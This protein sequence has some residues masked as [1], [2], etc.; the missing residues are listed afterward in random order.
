M[1]TNFE[2]GMRA[3]IRD[4]EWRIK[5]VDHSS[6]GGYVLACEGLSEL[7]LGREG[8]FLSELDP[9][10]ILDPTDTTLVDDTSSNFGAS[11]L[12]LDSMLRKTAP[13]D[14]HI[15]LGHRAAID[16]LNYQLEPALQALAQPRQRILIADAVGLGK[17]LEAGVLTSELIVRGRGK[18]I[19]VLAVKSMLAQFQQEFWNRFTIPLVRLDSVGLQRVRNRIP[20]N[21]NPF[22][23]FDRAII[24]IDT[25][26]HDIEYRHHL[27]QAYWDIVIIDE[28][29]NVADRGS[30][31]Q[32][33]KLARLMATRSDTLIMLSATPHDGK[34]ESFASLVNMLDPTAI[35]NPHDYAQEDYRDKGL[36]IRR[37]KKDVNDQLKGQFP[38]REI[39]VAK[40]GAT[41]AEEAAYDQ[42]MGVSFHTL[43][44]HGQGAGQLFRTTLEKTLFSSPAACLSTIQKRMARLMKRAERERDDERK[45]TLIED[46]DTLQCLETALTAIAPADFSKYQLLRDLLNGDMN[47]TASDPDD[48]LVIFTESLI[49]LDFLQEHLPRDLK[50][51]KN[52]VAMLRGDRRDRELMETVEAFNRRESPLRLLLCSDVASEGLNLHHLAHRMVHFDIPWS[53]MVFQQ[54]NGRI[55]RYGQTCQPQ[56]RYLLTESD[57]ERVRGDQRVLEVLIDKD[58]QAR[59][60]I[61]D[62]SEFLGLYDQEAEEEKVAEV[63]ED[64]NGNDVWK[65]FEA[66]MDQQVTQSE[67]PLDNFTPTTG[68][69]DQAGAISP[70]PGIFPS[71]LAY[72]RAA[73]RWFAEIGE[74]LDGGVDDETFWLTAPVDLKQRLAYLPREVRPPHDRFALTPDR[75]RIKQELDRVRQEE[76]TPWST[77]HYLW[78]LH[79]VMEWLSDRALNAFGRHTAPLLRLPGKLADDEHIVLIHGGFPNRRGHVL[80]QAWVGVRLKGDQVVDEL[81][82]PTLRER[83]ELKPGALPNPGKAGPTGDL[84]ALLPVAVAAV[85]KRLKARKATF[86]AQREPLLE[87]QRQ[88]LDQLRHRHE[89]Q[90]ELEIDRSDQLDAVKRSRRERGEQRIDRI[91]R[92]YRNWLDNTQTTEDEPYMQVA[93]VFTGLAAKETA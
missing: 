61:G 75:D 43:D 82:W 45:T 88:Q 36:V 42:L 55:D 78:P 73:L 2:P 11:L 8:L 48:R 23:Y 32:R 91:F 58:E 68:L 72:A 27:E 28:A 80:V 85:R 64:E 93:A 84:R 10:R 79:P 52:Q 31:S 50:L 5:R 21:H 39:Q 59:K 54:R 19:L 53:L 17:T 41:A 81:D 20:T 89:A 37:F 86:E 33:S 62:P 6:D 77:L 70:M 24:S 40:V 25:L 69:A 38:E 12:Y 63:L 26:K 4:A 71:G 87:K 46:F 65:A 76:D 60:N 57:H 83:L 29:Q 67:N 56:I 74:K 34:P 35:A 15:H 47:W 90:L 49:T 7:V 51:K 92:D 16:Q 13:A 22:H 3:E 66:L 14:E 18:R 30:H 9:I 1:Q 44:G